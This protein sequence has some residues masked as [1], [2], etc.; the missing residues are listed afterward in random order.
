MWNLPSG[1][2]RCTLLASANEISDP[3]ILAF[4]QSEIDNLSLLQFGGLQT[5]IPILLEFTSLHQPFWDSLVINFQCLLHYD[6]MFFNNSKCQYLLFNWRISSNLWFRL[7][8]S[9]SK[10]Y[11]LELVLLRS[12]KSVIWGFL[13]SELKGS[14]TWEVSLL[15]KRRSIF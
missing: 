9:V 6:F 10:S 2:D 12:K 13:L 11:C 5:S 1:H 15:L 8:N 14:G 7:F 4:L 3:L